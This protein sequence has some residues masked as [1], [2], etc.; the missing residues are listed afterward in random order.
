MKN[1]TAKLRIL[2][3]CFLFF[4]CHDFPIKSEPIRTTS[5]IY[6]ENFN[7]LHNC[8][9]EYWGDPLIPGDQCNSFM[10]CDYCKKSWG[11]IRIQNAI[12]RGK[13]GYSIEIPLNANHA[14]YPGSTP[15]I[16]F[17]F[18]A[19]LNQFWFRFYIYLS[20]NFFDSSSNC[21]HL[22]FTGTHTAGGTV[23]IDF[24]N[25]WSLTQYPAGANFVGGRWIGLHGSSY[26]GRE[27]F[28]S[29]WDWHLDEHLGEWIC[30]EIHSNLK[31]QFVQ[32]WINGELHVSS[33]QFVFSKPQIF[34]AIGHYN[35]DR[36][37]TD[38]S[39]TRYLY[40][41]D[42]ALSQTGYIGPLDQASP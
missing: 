32:L 13:T 20:N 40:I 11:P 15:Y 38:P 41:D 17:N 6:T 42:V 33:D 12:R 36:G 7:N 8:I 5:F 9:D 21:T 2:F 25:R 35:C 16:D 31:N 28:L 34:F 14:G 27:L 18:G 39:K 4:S 22:T 37:G 1:V 10:I 30:I 26:G 3:L 29:K 23:G 24:R 19:N